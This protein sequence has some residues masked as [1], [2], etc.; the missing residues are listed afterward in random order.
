MSG[1]QFEAIINEVKETT[2]PMPH[3]YRQGWEDACETVRSEV[4]RR[5]G[6]VDGLFRE[7]AV[8][9]TATTP[10]AVSDHTEYLRRNLIHATAVGV[11][12]NLGA[13]IDRLGKMKRPPKW[14]VDL[15]QRTHGN[16]AKLSP[17]LAR[18]RNAA[19]DAPAERR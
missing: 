5:A 6:R 14:L 18:W 16:A 12:A 17:E 10:Q 1:A 13:A 19:P 2:S 9:A 15:L 4:Y 7:V 11:H 8:D 3:V